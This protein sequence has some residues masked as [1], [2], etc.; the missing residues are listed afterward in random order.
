M[1]K[2]KFSGDTRLKLAVAISTLPFNDGE[3]GIVSAFQQMG[4]SISDNQYASTMDS[5]IQQLTK[6]TDIDEILFVACR[7][8][9]CIQTYIIRVV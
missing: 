4:P 9:T 3:W 5:E 7:Y 8:A 6:H 1:P 2:T